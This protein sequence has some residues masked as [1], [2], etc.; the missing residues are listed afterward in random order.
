MNTTQFSSQEKSETVLSVDDGCAGVCGLHGVCTCLSSLQYRILVYNGDVD[1]ACNFMGDE[2]FVDSLNQQVPLFDVQNISIIYP[3]LPLTDGLTL[4]LSG[5]G[6][7][8]SVALS[9]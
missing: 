4:T 9:G 1:M 5:G 2:W 3:F 6:R 8:T 7:E